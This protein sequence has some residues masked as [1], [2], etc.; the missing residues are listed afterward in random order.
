MPAFQ[1]HRDRGL[2]ADVRV[3][4]SLLAIRLSSALCVLQGIF[5][6]IIL[7]LAP[8]LAEPA[9]KRG[10]LAAV[11]VVFAMTSFLTAL[12]LWKRSPPAIHWFAVWAVQWV[13]VCGVLPYLFS[14]WRSESW[15]TLFS[16]VVAMSL[17]VLFLGRYIRDRLVELRV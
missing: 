5:G 12:A 6:C 4:K 14:A 13:L 9:W 1:P 8:G 2:I 16:G 11:M 15:L 3:A 17:A 7:V 10:L